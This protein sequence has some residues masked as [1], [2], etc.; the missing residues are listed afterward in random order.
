MHDNVHIYNALLLA[1]GN[2]LELLLRDA[3]APQGS[4]NFLL[5]E[6]LINLIKIIFIAGFFIDGRWVEKRLH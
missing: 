2:F 3:T 5:T 1:F 4:K 6:L